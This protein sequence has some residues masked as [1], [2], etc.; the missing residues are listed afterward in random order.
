[1]YGFKFQISE[2]HARPTYTFSHALSQWCFITVTFLNFEH[3]A[4]LYGEFQEY[5]SSFYY[6]RR[7]LIIVQSLDKLKWGEKSKIPQLNDLLI[8]QEL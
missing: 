5:H 3:S 4:G 7:K 2:I 8:I 6:L 1:M